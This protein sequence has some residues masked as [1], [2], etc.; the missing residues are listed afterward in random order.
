MLSFERVDS[1]SGL[2]HSVVQVVNCITYEA[3]C[4]GAHGNYFGGQP[5]WMLETVKR[6]LQ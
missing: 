1:N 6:L 4:I 2:P 3:I 5:E